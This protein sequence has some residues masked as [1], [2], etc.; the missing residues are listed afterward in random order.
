MGEI[1]LN[2]NRGDI[3]Y[4]RFILEGYDG[5]GMVTTKNP[6]AARIL[7]SFPLSRKDLITRL[8][9]ALENEGVIREDNSL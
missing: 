4:I 7:L 2:V 9:H 1:M 5:L 8:I 3:S 6:H